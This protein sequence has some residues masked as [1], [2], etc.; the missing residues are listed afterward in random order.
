VPRTLIISTNWSIPD[1]PGKSGCPSMSSAM[2][3][4][5]DQ[6]S[7]LSV[8]SS[9]YDHPP[10]ADECPES[11]ALLRGPVRGAMWRKEHTDVGRVVRRAKDQFRRT[12]VA[13]ANVADVG[14]ARNEN[15]GRTKVAQLQDTRGGVEE[16][17]LGLD[18]TVTDAYRVDV[19]K[20]S[21]KLSSQLGTQSIAF[22][23]GRRRTAHLVHVQL[24]LQ[25]RH[26]LLQFRVVSR[27]A[28]YGLGDKFEHQVEVNFVLLSLSAPSRPAQSR[29]DGCSSRQLTFSPFE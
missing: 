14:F 2:T 5:V 13:R 17:V 12:V 19:G 11:H 25:H 1:S 10:A 26:R 6:M 16:Q 18:V 21:E 15:L 24:D 4:P 3:Q 22:N 8:G 23:T 28:V 7:V 29:R 9:R 27:S 20:G